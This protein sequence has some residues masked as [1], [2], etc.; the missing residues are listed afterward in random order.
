[1]EFKSQ[2]D[3]KEFKHEQRRTSMDL[4]WKIENKQ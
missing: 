4:K 1:M 3:H 2:K